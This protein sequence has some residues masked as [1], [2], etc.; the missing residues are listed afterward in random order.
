[1]IISLPVHTAVCSPRASGTFVMLVEVQVSS[2][3]GGPAA[4]VLPELLGRK[5]ASNAPVAI[6]KLPQTRTATFL[7][8]PDRQVPPALI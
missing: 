4:G 7:F 6:K 3:H 5:T 1:M 2:V 8:I